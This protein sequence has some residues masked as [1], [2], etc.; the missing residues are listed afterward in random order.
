MTT[1]VFVTD[2]PAVEPVPPCVVY[3]HGRHRS[4]KVAA[5]VGFLLENFAHAPWAQR[6]GAT[7]FRISLRSVTNACGAPITILANEGCS[8]SSS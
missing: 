5:M 1:I 2:S 3:P 6:A 8:G 7:C 4:P